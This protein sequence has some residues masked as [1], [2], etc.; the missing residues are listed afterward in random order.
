MKT[1][2]Q[3]A[4]RTLV[5]AREDFQAM[6]KRMD[7]R[8]G[9][10][11]DGAQQNLIEGRHFREEDID[12]FD[13]IAK[14][15]RKQEKNV[16]KMLKHNLKCFAIYIYFLDQIK[17]VGEIAAGH[18][19]GQFDIEE[20]STVSKMWQYAGLNPGKVRGKQRVEVNKY[21]DEMGEISRVI[22][23]EKGKPEAFI[24]TTNELIRGD[25]PTPG[26]VLPY[27]K[28]LRTA[29]V[30]VLADGFIKA[31]SYYALEYYYPYKH[32]LEQEDEWKDES[33]GHRDRAAKRYMIK[34]FI[35]DLYVAWRELEGLSV[36]APY[37][38]EYLN[39]KHKAT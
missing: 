6:R 25:R 11:A 18:I 4:I 39:H 5:R 23:N 30:G 8:L 14:E 27:N 12:N 34:M 28:P 1:Q 9:R 15:A 38:E 32:R 20:A 29:L 35:K 16:E 19:I 24:V 26:F 21:K 7:N 17:G 33:K 36:R 37:Q 31:Q 3:L 10:K 22:Y 2:D 13:A